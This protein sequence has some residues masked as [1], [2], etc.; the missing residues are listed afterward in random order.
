MKPVSYDS[1][2]GE[3]VSYE[4]FLRTSTESLLLEAGSSSEETHPEYQYYFSMIGGRAVLLVSV[5]IVAKLK[6]TYT[7]YSRSNPQL[8]TK[9]VSV[10]IT[11]DKAIAFA[12]R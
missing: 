4:K 11:S 3:A 5:P 7:D 6:V 2:N 1:R 8:E 12:Y 9:S 10:I